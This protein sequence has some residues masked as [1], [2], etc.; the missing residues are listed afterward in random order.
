MASGRRVVG[1]IRSLVIARDLQ[2]E[3]A[4][5][6]HETVFVP[7]LMYGSETMLWKERERSRLRAVQMYILRG[8][9]GI[10]RIDRV[11]NA[12]IRELCRVTKR[13]DERIDEPQNLTRCHSYMNPL[14]GNLSVAK[15]IT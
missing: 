1:A 12:Q 9:L 3:Y 15:P 2:L 14:G 10:R 6:L 8:M 7:V 4:R 5:F 13:L 11:P